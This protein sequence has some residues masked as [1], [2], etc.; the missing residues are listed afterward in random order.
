MRD[1]LYANA[2]TVFDEDMTALHAEVDH[3]GFDPDDLPDVPVWGGQITSLL[4][5]VSTVIDQP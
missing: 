4:D 1:V 2:A 5:V 3:V